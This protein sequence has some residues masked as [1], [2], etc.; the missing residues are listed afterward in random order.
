MLLGICYLYM[1]TIERAHSPAKMWEKIKLPAN[2]AQALTKI[3]ENLEYWPNYLIHKAKQRLTK[4]HQYLI[5]MRK[6]ELRNQPELVPINKKREK[7]E[8]AR[9]TKALAAAQLDRSIKKELLERLKKNVYGDIYSFPQKHFDE[10]LDEI[11]TEIDEDDEQQVEFVEG[12]SDLEDWDGS[13]D[14]GN[15]YFFNFHHNSIFW[16][17]INVYYR[18]LLLQKMDLVMIVMMVLVEMKVMKKMMKLKMDLMIVMMVI[19]LM[20]VKFHQQ[21]D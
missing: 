3:D 2:Y 4:I 14:M 16:M 8:R 15:V 9:E 1:K 17:Y 7:R 6:L 11:E 13:W 20:K 12:D 19:L 5:R 18:F 21:L 10:A